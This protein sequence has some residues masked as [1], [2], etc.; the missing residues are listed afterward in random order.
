MEKKI[1]NKY[2]GSLHSL[3]IWW[4]LTYTRMRLRL[5]GFFHPPSAIFAFSSLPAWFSRGR[6]PNFATY[7]EV[8]RIWRSKF[9]GHYYYYYHCCRCCCCCKN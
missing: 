7:S 3:K 8:S 9:G 1:K 6:Q 5:R 4:T 2:E